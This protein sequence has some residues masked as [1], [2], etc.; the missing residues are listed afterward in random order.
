MI[1]TFTLIML[2]SVT[3]FAAG[4]VVFHFSRSH[5]SARKNSVLLKFAGAILIAG[6]ILSF[7]LNTLIYEK[8]RDEGK[9]E[10]ILPFE[11]AK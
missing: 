3:T 9:I 4:F 2:L 1:F 7:V 11:V 6:G 8:F 5:N 10:Q